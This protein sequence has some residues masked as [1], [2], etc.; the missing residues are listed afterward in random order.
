MTNKKRLVLTTMANDDPLEKKIC[1]AVMAKSDKV[2]EGLIESIGKMAD[3]E[4]KNCYHNISLFHCPRIQC[5]PEGQPGDWDWF[6]EQRLKDFIEDFAENVVKPNEYLSD[7]AWELFTTGRGGATLTPRLCLSNTY[8]S[9]LIRDAVSRQVQMDNF[10][11]TD[12]AEHECRRAKAFYDTLRK[13]ND[14]VAESL[15][16]LPEDWK[17]ELEYRIQEKKEAVN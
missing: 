10:S 5:T 15:E 3:A 2:W 7:T 1:L 14:M 9:I 13:L 12:E 6:I 8:G 4:V 11:D 17:Q 16:A